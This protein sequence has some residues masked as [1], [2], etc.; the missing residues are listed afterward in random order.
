MIYFV[1]IDD[2]ICYNDTTDKTDY[3]LAKPY[4]ERIN[5]IN[6]L[7]DEGNT[8]VYWTARGTLSGINW[9]DVTIKQ[10]N[11]WNCKYHE[12]RMGKPYYDIFIDDKNINSDVFFQ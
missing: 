1:D 7:F 12:L 5:K 11:K 10:L 6:S 9:F 2:T 4:Y 8:I 3:K